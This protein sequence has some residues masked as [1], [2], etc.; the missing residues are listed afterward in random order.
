[1]NASAPTSASS[2]PRYSRIA[3][4]GG[5]LPHNRVTNAQLADRLAA[6]CVE[7]SDDW[8]TER[9]GIKSRH[10][11]AEGE[12]TSDLGIAAA[13]KALI[14][15]GIDPVEIDLVICATAT[16]DR[17]STTRGPG[18]APRRISACVRL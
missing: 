14:R 4:T 15:A 5:Y 10:I 7:T 8:I 11:A 6:A 2:V 17:S 3:G 18:P 9:T 16:P 1:M 12:L 13:R